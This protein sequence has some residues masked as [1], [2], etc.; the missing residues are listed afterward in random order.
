MQKIKYHI[1]KLMC[2]AYRAQHLETPKLRPSQDQSPTLS[3]SNKIEKYNFRQ[4]SL[5]H[6]LIKHLT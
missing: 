5:T 4:L 1:K 2:H 6:L 3:I